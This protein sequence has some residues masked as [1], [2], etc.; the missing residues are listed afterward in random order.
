MFKKIKAIG[1]L[2]NS[3][4]VVSVAFIFLYKFIFVNCPEWIVG[5]SIVGEIFFNI[6]LAIIASY[7]FYFIVVHNKDFNEKKIV[8]NIFKLKLQNIIDVEN[9][10]LNKLLE[11]AK[12]SIN[13]NTITIDTLKSVFH[14]IK[15]N[16][17]FDLMFSEIQ[18]YEYKLL[19]FLRFY[20]NQTNSII[21]DIYQL[22]HLEAVLIQKLNNIE[23]SDYIKMIALFD[24]F[25]EYEQSDLFP[26]AESFFEY[27]KLVEE[28]SE[29]IRKINKRY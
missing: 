13:E 25:K 28:L 21:K 12:V 27:Q 18:V 17:N 15:V 24:G 11:L 6:F 16:Q 2:L 22:P 29:Y 14:K 19:D 23:T 4:M 10:T 8:S 9:T 3:L 5:A 7:I 1:I 26:F 20:S